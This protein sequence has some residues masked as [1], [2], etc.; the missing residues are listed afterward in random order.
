MEVTFTFSYCSFF[1]ARA[2]S[3]EFFYSKNTL[4]NLPLHHFF[5]L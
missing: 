3:T 4:F 2:H 1:G 5:I